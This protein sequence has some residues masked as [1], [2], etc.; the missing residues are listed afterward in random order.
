MSK[1]KDNEITKYKIFKGSKCNHC[2]IKKYNTC[3]I[4]KYR[5]ST[6]PN[7]KSTNIMSF[8][9]INKNKQANESITITNSADFLIPV[10]KRDTLD[11][12]IPIKTISNDTFFTV[13][14][15]YV[16]SKVTEYFRINLYITISISFNNQ[17]EFN[18]Y[19]Q[20]IFGLKAFINIYK[21]NNKATEIGTT[22]SS[23]IFDE[24]NLS[25][26]GS[27]KV[28]V[29]IPS[30]YVEIKDELR[31][32][33]RLDLSNVILY[34][35]NP[36]S[37]NNP[38][39]NIIIKLLCTSNEEEQYSTENNILLDILPVAYIHEISC[40]N[41]W[42]ITSQLPYIKTPVTISPETQ[43]ENSTYYSIYNDKII[44]KQNCALKMS[45]NPF[46]NYSISGLQIQTRVFY[47]S[48]KPSEEAECKQI[49]DDDTYYT[50][51][52]KV[53]EANQ[54][55][56][57]S[58]HIDFELDCKKDEKISFYFESSIFNT[59]TSKNSRLLLTL[60]KPSYLYV[61]I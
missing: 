33:L 10:S 47:K 35:K 14:E 8:S 19:G 49:P 12:Q 15:D 34:N 40:Y 51:I 7:S 29:R 43:I 61:T 45:F 1:F 9:D 60:L 58:I 55:I 20:L 57:N 16:A 22:I 2:P 46:I 37:L 17:N 42:V 53:D 44:I 41:Y 28:I 54:D 26:T 59:E 4:P 52:S 32:F 25:T 18:A 36:D 23:I 6:Y 5:N 13:Q 24:N 31:L 48:E 38:Y 50:Y 56:K 27:A 11:Y 39:D 3:S 30:T 21:K